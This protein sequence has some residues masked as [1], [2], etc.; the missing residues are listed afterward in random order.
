MCI[1]SSETQMN[2]LSIQLQ[3]HECL[4]Q[5][6]SRSRHHLICIK[7]FPLNQS[8]NINAKIQL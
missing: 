3:M 1:M 7:Q 8:L 4:K 6:F 2:R 5:M